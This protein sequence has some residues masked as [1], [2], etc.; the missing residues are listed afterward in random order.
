MHYIV[1]NHDFWIGNFFTK[2]LGIKVYKEPI[3]LT[4]QG[5][6]TF[7][8]HGD[9]LF[10]YDPIRFVLRNKINIFLFSLLRPYIG[11]RIARLVSRISRKFSA[12]KTIKWKKLYKIACQKLDEGY[13]AVI[14]GHIH[15]PRHLKYKKK[16]FLL[17]GDWIR[18]FSYGKLEDGKFKLCFWEQSESSLP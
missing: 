5:K 9:E 13:D 1:G 14:L 8:A 16:E 10:P 12:K 4:I 3:T 15:S 2:T 6:K 18:N 11:L 17:I 7:L